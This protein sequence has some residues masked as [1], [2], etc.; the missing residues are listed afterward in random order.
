MDAE[1]P[2]ILVIE[3]EPSVAKSIVNYL[4]DSGL[5]SLSATDGRQGLEMF[6]R[7]EPDV[8]LLDL[9]LPKL[10]GIDVLKSI[11]E[12]S[13]SVAVIV[14]SGK[15]QMNDAIEALRLGA[16]DYL[17]K[18]IHDMEVLG[19][20]VRRAMERVELRR[21][22]QRYRDHLESEVKLRTAELDNANR[23]LTAKNTALHEVLASIEAERKQVGK[24]V[25]TNVERVVL[26]QLRSLKNGLNRQQQRVIEQV[27]QELGEIVSP[28]ID[29]VS[30]NVASLTT[31]ELRVCNF[32]KRG[33]AVKEIAEM[34]HLSPETIAAH[35][36]SIRRKLGIANQKVNLTTYLQTVFDHTEP[37]AR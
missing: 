17:C 16:W 33:L 2:K 5:R 10:D 27:E 14:V 22:N 7:H 3:D 32:I 36:R 25:Q 15:G 35:R 30:R 9:R 20:S 6:R 13:S 4:I 12:L 24:Q 11:R 26:P 37:A 34:E 29:K 8:V 28:F 23:A 19:H 1:K 31:T 18:P 21:E